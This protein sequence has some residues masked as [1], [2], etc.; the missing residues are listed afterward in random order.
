MRGNGL[1]REGLYKALSA[2][3]NPSLDTLVKVLGALALRMAVE[4]RT[5]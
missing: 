4:P 1:M 2:E 5:A 3:G